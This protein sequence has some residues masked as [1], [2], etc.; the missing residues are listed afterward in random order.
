MKEHERTNWKWTKMKEEQI[1]NKMKGNAG[2][3]KNIT[4]QWKKQKKGGHTI[5]EE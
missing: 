4:E 5:K 3:W 2:T 1:N